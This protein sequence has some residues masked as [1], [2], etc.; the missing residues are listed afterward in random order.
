[1]VFEPSLKITLRCVIR[2]ACSDLGEH[3]GDLLCCMPMEEAVETAPGLQALTFPLK[4]YYFLRAAPL[5]SSQPTTQ[6]HSF[7]P[8][9]CKCLRY[10]LGVTPTPN[11]ASLLPTDI[12]ACDGHQVESP[13]SKSTQSNP[14][15]SS[16]SL[17]L[18]L[19]SILQ[20]LPTGFLQEQTR[21]LLLL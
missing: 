9:L 18:P 2:V 3:A 14:R 13:K 15:S 6:L 20:H 12:R 11:P 21:V 10:C 7:T 19:E 4:S 17:I 16:A 1:M 5:L 8:R